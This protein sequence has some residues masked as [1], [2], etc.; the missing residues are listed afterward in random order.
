MNTFR[1]H[2]LKQ[3]YA[4]SR[5]YHSWKVQCLPWYVSWRGHNQPLA[6][7]FKLDTKWTFLH[8]P[9]SENGWE[10]LTIWEVWKKSCSK[11]ALLLEQ[12]VKN[13]QFGLLPASNM[14]TEESS[15]RFCNSP[16][17][18]TE[19]SEKDNSQVFIRDSKSTLVTATRLCS[20]R[21]FS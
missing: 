12:L 4:N 18:N 11:L 1:Y 21:A 8:V 3:K 13:R 9:L 16:P 19:H 2:P 15:W 6:G 5:L 14:V 20:E 17:Y 7:N 10:A